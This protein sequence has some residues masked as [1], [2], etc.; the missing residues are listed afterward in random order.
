MFG[1]PFVKIESKVHFEPPQDHT[2]FVLIPY[3][4]ICMRAYWMTF[5]VLLFIPGIQYN[6]IR[7][8]SIGGK[9]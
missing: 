6:T 7:R 5:K 4:D 8:H 3:A 9:Q 1:Q 2:N